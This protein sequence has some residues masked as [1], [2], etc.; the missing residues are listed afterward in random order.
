MTLRL[1]YI[2]RIL[3]CV[4]LLVGFV[5]VANAL[6][7][8]QPPAAAMDPFGQPVES[9]PKG[10][11]ST[12]KAVGLLLLGGWLFGQLA[13][14]LGFSKITG[15]LVF[16][17]LAAPKVGTFLLGEGTTWVLSVEQQPYLTLV[18]DLAITLIA[19]TAGCKIDL[20][21]IRDSFR[22]LSLILAFEFT[23][24]LI[25]VAGLMAFMLSSNPIF[26]EYGG[27]LTVIL[28]A[29]VIGIVA[30]ANSPA[31]VIAVLSETGA[32][33]VMAQTSLAVTV[34][35]DLL[36][37]IV[38]AVVLGLASDAASSAQQ[39]AF[40]DDTPPASVETADA[41]EPGAD[42]NTVG[43]TERS[44]NSVILKLTKQI[45]GSLVGGSLIGIALAWYLRR[46]D[47]YLSI[48]LTLGSF[49]IAL[50][51][52]ELGL[53]PLLVGLGAGV[54]IANA[55]KDSK[56]ALYDVVENLSV[57]V[58]ILF[59]A[60][61][62]TKINPGLLGEVWTY[63]L[64][65]VVLRMTAV[66]AGTALGCKAS[67]LAP[68]ASRWLWT[69]FVPQAGISLA[70]AVVVADEFSD[71][72]FSNK[73]YAILLSAIAINELVGPILFKLGLERAGETQSKRRAT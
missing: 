51:S 30:T 61:A 45:G 2:M 24:V 62:G 8:S 66:W 65:L 27:L 15:C 52:A 36:L 49:A 59:F 37:I 56:P 58:Y 73:I 43:A 20:R 12:A 69:A 67:G 13:S 63:V 16:G 35:K 72:A 34:C 39:A 64:A 46:T 70:L 54:T 48:I 60:V 50:V 9:F 31:V 26:S 14:A 21:E 4:A 40:A 3:G 47:A 1:P 55:Y 57:P 17:L 32:K 25:V 41:Y 28:V 11:V 6:Q 42:S 5:V 38:F 68:P 33:G 10:L 29:T 23:L 44:G 22:S 7:P 71:F 18:N 53:K 19:L